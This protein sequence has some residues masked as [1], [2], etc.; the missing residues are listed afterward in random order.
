MDVWVQSCYISSVLVAYEPF[1]FNTNFRHILVSLVHIGNIL[2][3]SSYFP[4]PILLLNLILFPTTTLIPNHAKIFLASLTFDSPFSA[5]L[6]R[7]IYV[8]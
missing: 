7:H 5:A 6:L 8:D 4:L 2:L 3:F 1:W